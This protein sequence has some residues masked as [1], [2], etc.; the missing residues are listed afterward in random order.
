[1]V[2]SIGLTSDNM[3]LT[4]PQPPGTWCISMSVFALRE[5]TS[6]CSRENTDFLFN[7][8]TLTELNIELKF[9]TC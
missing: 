1:M 2:T 8:N 6:F 3:A 4:A 5:T 9:K 7:A